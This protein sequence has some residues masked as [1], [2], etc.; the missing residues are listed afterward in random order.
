MISFFN[1]KEFNG[2]S[3]L[4][5]NAFGDY[6]F[7]SKEDFNKLLYKNESLDHFVREELI[8]S[9]MLFDGSSYHFIDENVPYARD[10]KNYLFTA[11]SLHIFVVTT[12]CNHRCVYCQANDGQPLYAAMDNCTAEKAVDVAL[13]SPSMYLS[14]EIQG[15]E[16]LLNFPVIKHIVEYTEAKNTKKEIAFSVVTNL[17]AITDE[18]IGFFSDH[19]VAV[20]TSLDG[21][22]V[23]H[24]LNRPYSNGS[25]SFDD[26]LK[27]VKKVRDAGIPVGAILTTTRSSFPY[28]NEIVE[29]YCNNGFSSIFVRPLTPLG[30]AKRNWN[31]IGYTADEFVQ[32]YIRVFQAVLKKCQEGYHIQEN[33]ASILLAG[34]LRKYPANYMELRSPCGAVTGQMAYY[35]NGDVFSCDEGRMIFEMGDASFRLGNV[36][37]NTYHEMVS[38]STCRALCLAST[39]EAVPTC[40]DCVYQP[41]CGICP[42][43]NLALYKDLLPKEP[44]HYRCK[45][46]MGI[47][48]YLFGLLQADECA[49]IDTLKTW[50]L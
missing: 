29:A 43:I 27:A 37:E 31:T 39:T 22:S 15:G 42:V 48:D 20:S 4:L 11:T 21:N 3:Y 50:C 19:N 6:A 16:P 24:N 33:F 2:N 49:V 5:T 40:C 13:Q 28:A 10:S 18:M 41:Y 30:C 23:V 9:R 35:V 46:N 32:F 1:F 7:L 47:L 14:F 34:I 45:I 8:R 38:S 36:F 25:G 26:V 44:N 17:T 12:Q